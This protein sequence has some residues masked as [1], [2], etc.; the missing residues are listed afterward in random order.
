MNKRDISRAC[1]TC[2]FFEKHR[3]RA[4]SG[5]CLLDCYGDD[6]VRAVKA[7]DLCDYWVSCTADEDD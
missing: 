1:G 4:N 2:E 3:D 5:D 7:D 6:G